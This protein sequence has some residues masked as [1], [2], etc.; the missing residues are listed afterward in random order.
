MYLGGRLRCTHAFFKVYEEIGEGA[1]ELDLG[2]SKV[3]MRAYCSWFN[4]RGADQQKKLSV[5]SGGERNRL[6]LAKVGTPV[7]AFALYKPL[8]F[9]LWQP[10]CLHVQHC[11]TCPCGL[12]SDWAQ[13]VSVISTLGSSAE[14]ACAPCRS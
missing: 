13:P 3:N 8:S 5:L 10:L 2:G 4:F 11:Q 7:S 12:P 14:R 9:G 6:Q 1:D